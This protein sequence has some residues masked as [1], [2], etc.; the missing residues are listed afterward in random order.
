MKTGQDT[1]S[2]I[3]PK[4]REVNCG[5]RDFRAGLL[6]I[7]LLFLGTSCSQQQSTNPGA[8]VL[9]AGNDIVGLASPVKLKPD[10]TK[11]YLGDY[12]QYP[13]KIDSVRFNPGVNFLFSNGDSIIRVIDFPG[14]KAI[15]TL[16]VI[17]AGEPYE[18]PVFRS[19][20]INYHFSYKPRNENAQSVAIR[21]N[22]N[23]WNAAANPL[24]KEGDM[25]VTD[26]TL[27]PAL[28]E[29]LV[30]EDG[31]EMLDPNN[32]DKKDNGQGGFNS[33]FRVG[34]EAELAFI[35]TYGYLRDSIV[36]HYP[37]SLNNPAV[38]WQNRCLDSTWF[39]RRGNR[40]SMAIPAAADTMDR[41]DIRVYGMDRGRRTNDLLIPLKKGKPLMQA[42]DLPRTDKHR[43]AMYFLMVDRFVDADTSNDF[44]V[45]DP[46]ILPPANYY[47]GDLEGVSN[48][49]TNGYISELGM[50]TVW[51]SPITQ[52]PLGAYGL[53]DKGGVRSKFS[54]YHGYWPISS[55]EVDFRFGTGE[56]LTALIDSAHHEGMNVILDYVANHVHEEHPVY[57]Q[58]PDWAT[59][60]YL[61]DGSLNTERWDEYRLTTWFDTFMPTLDLRKPEVVR[62]MTDSALFWFENY[63]IDGFRHDA[64]KHIPLNFW[65]RLTRKLKYRVVVPENRPIYQI[66][67]TYGSPQLIDSY[68][69]SGLL[70]A[71][72]DFN[73]YD[74]AVAAFAKDEGGFGNLKRVL[75]QSLEVYGSHHLMG[76]ISG[77]QDRT[78]FISYADGSVDFGED[79]KLAGWTRKITIQDTIGYNRLAMLHAFNFTIPGVPVIYYG[80]EIGLPG[81]NDPDNRRMMRFGESL[82]PKEKALL[83]QVTRIAN[84]RKDNMALLYGDLQVLASSDLTFSYLRNYF[85]K[86]A[87]VLFNSS[88]EEKTIRLTIPKSIHT[89]GLEANFGHDYTLSENTITITLAPVSFEILTN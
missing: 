38:F 26:L 18:I 75:N 30:V 42:A 32:P 55:S 76:N 16:A 71:Q 2:G 5:L 78:R 84:L 21:G 66:G 12:F 83:N 7:A 14:K 88:R 65:R 47:G 46:E 4:Q 25:W 50:N 17:Y 51:L 13:E 49:I 45:Q 86:T 60:L 80:D 33:T 87:V 67:E 89:S 9:H 64:T 10:T 20:K 6:F 73:L 69:G 37:G 68:I 43:L 72:F 23:G 35:S 36:I 70:D 24:R 53:W 1:N 61:P 22:F 31:E 54:G 52:N 57:K 40:L 56:Q 77:N 15:A 62:A 39:H 8:G 29:Y 41:S 28:Y 58:H 44:P 74:A 81:A 11:I 59:N 82:K 19:R 3:K 63:P 34:T 79:A 27:E 85:D 48:K